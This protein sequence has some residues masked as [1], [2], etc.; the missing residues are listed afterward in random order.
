MAGEQ[1]PEQHEPDKNEL[2]PD[3]RAEQPDNTGDSPEAIVA[4]YHLAVERTRQIK[5]RGSLHQAP[6]IPKTGPNIYY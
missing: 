1:T 2:K 3:P 5:D 6:D 4:L